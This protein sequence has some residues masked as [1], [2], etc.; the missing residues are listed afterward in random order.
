MN[1]R[2]DTVVLGHYFAK[3]NALYADDTL[4]LR[5]GKGVFKGN[6][7]LPKGVYF[8]F[9]DRK[10]F[11]II[12]GDNQQ[13]GIAAD[14]ADFVNRTR[15][16]DSPDNTVFYEFQ[17]YNTERSAGFYELDSQL[18]T[19]ATDAEK[20]DIRNRMQALNK[21]RVDFIQKLADD[22]A[23]LY[24]GKFLN[25]LIPVETRLPEPPRDAG[26]RVTDSTY[27]YRWYRSHFFDDLNIYDPDMLRNPLYE[28]K[29]IKY[30]TGVI[31]QYYGPDTLC[32]EID[33][34]MAKA[35]ANDEIFRCVLI[36]LFNYY[37]NSKVMVHENV[38]VHIAEKWY[39]PHATF[40]GVDFIENL[41]KEVT[42]RKPN[43]IGQHAPPLE[44]L[45]VLPPD[46]FKAAALDTAI[47]ND[48]Y[49]GMSVKDFRQSVKGKYTAV[50]FWD[51]ACSHCQKAIQDLHKVFEEYQNRG[52]TVITIQTV[53]SKEAKSK[54][55]DFANEHNLFGWTNA[56]SPFSN[57]YNA[58]YDISSTPKL[59]LL[60]ENEIIVGKNLA[61]EQIKDFIKI[62]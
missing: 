52:L 6:K 13:F 38:W 28:D 4:V 47:K 19:A 2:N 3:S 22:N 53:V 9:N 36:T 29:L 18:K 34:V 57:T 33:R 58:L 40:S 54:W 41:K 23:G 55:I 31:P 30:V 35:K 49:A 8:I 39:I 42:K 7:T 21:D 5:N 15:F 48:L 16:T 60:D 51:Y 11:D 56:W 1:S 20:N 45:Q 46:H 25:S 10:K 26:G 44:M 37:V 12:M 24:V 17:K 27:V 59:F 61:P 62:N 50:F 43:L 32:A 14:T